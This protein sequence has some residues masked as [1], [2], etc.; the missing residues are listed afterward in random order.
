MDVQVYSVPGEELI[1]VTRYP[2]ELVQE[3]ERDTDIGILYA[4][5]QRLGSPPRKGSFQPR[6]ANA[7]CFRVANELPLDYV[8]TST[9]EPTQILPLRMM[10]S[11]LVRKH[12]MTDLLFVKETCKPLYEQVIHRFVQTE[13]CFRRILL[14]VVNDEG[15]VELIYTATRQF[16]TVGPEFLLTEMA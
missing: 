1:E 6:S 11:E 4:S 15:R 13:L 14:P 8:Y 10:D 16:G 12:A 2:I 3:V 7:A 5:W 9:D